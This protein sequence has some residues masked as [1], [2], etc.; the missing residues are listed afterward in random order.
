[1]SRGILSY[2][3]TVSALFGDDATILREVDFQLLLIAN[4]VAPLGTALISPLLG[5][6]QGPFGA[7]DATIGLMMTAFTAPAVVVIPLAGATADYYGRKPLLVLG[8]LLFSVAGISMALTTDYLL[9]LGLRFC[10][11][12]GFAAV[13][14]TIITS[15]GDLYTGSAE[16]AG[17]GF[18]F[19]ASG[20]TQT[21]FPLVGGLLVTIAWQYPLFLYAIGLP[22]ALVLAKYFEEPAT[23]AGNDEPSIRE[24][25]VRDLLGLVSQPR[26][27]AILVV[28]TIPV[29]L[30]ITFMTYIS[31]LVGQNM[32]GTPSEAGA[33]VALASV[34]YAGSATQMGRVSVFFRGRVWLLTAATLFMTAGLVTIAFAQS[35]GI[36]AL[37]VLALGLGFGVALSLLR[38]VVTGFAPTELR[39]GLVSSAESLGRLSA[40]VAPVVIGVLI[41]TVGDALGGTAALQTTIAGV[42]VVAGIIGVS[43][44]GIALLAPTVVGKNKP[45]SCD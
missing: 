12:L 20:F 22:I 7:T 40:T 27:A 9:V 33:L 44:L 8:L 35:I 13:T 31:L 15:I 42:A 39:G 28:R 36:A 34:T 32:G 1:M 2:V 3:P 26:V 24:E 30:Y 37:G 43:S 38:S 18:R 25:Y 14:P 45:M 19:A 29:F 16:A 17:Q 10:Q 5:S 11:G 41:S 21:L 23:E 4:L 6:L